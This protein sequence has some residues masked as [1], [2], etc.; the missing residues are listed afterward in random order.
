[1]Y[2]IFLPVLIQVGLTLAILTFLPIKRRRDLKADP[3]LMQ[4]ASLD[5]TL[6]SEDSRKTANSYG[7]QFELPVLFYVACVFAIL[8]GATGWWTGLLAW[9][10]VLSRIAHAVIHTTINVVL[11]RFAAF[12]VGGFTLALLW[13]TVAIAA[14]DAMIF[15]LDDLQI[16]RDQFENGAGYMQD[17]FLN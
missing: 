15:E 4:R 8:F 13:L 12:A 16:L 3:A 5:S 14:G 1:M 2:S 7:S 6:Y 10:F 11:F 17:G 9:T